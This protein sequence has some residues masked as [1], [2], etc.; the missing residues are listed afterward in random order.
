MP[1]ADKVA[2]TVREAP[3]PGGVSRSRGLLDPEILAHAS[4]DALRKFNPRAQVRNPV[5]FVVLI[6]TTVTLL[7][8]IAHPGIFTWSVTVWLALTVAFANFAEAMA[9]GRGKAQANA[10]R[11]MRTETDGRRLRPGGTEER[12]AAAELVKGDL[13]IAEAGDVIPSDG[14]I[15][16]GGASVDESAITGESAPVIREAGGD[17]SAVTGGTTA[18]SDRIVV[19]ITA[20]RGHT[21]LDRMIT[22]VE[23]T[24]RRKTPNEI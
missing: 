17:R 16:E 2:A 11:R 15:I 20:E 21:F 12:V 8:A 6:G 3:V 10:L 24:S 18:L 5:M 23:G 13:V 19:R 14:E 9:E 7:E 1:S 4:L 22:L